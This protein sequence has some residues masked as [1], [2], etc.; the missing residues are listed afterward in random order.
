MGPPGHGCVTPAAGHVARVILLDSHPLW[1]RGTDEGPSPRPL[2]VSE[3]LAGE[4]QRTGS[5]PQ[6]CRLEP[7]AH[8][9]A[10]SLWKSRARRG[11]DLGLLPGLLAQ[12]VW[13]EGVG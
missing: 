7:P 4:G 1:P 5:R 8:T 2:L 6:P 11:S 13:R 12:P 9:P 10:I 3:G